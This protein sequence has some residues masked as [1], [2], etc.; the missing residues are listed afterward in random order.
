MDANEP[1]HDQPITS[2]GINIGKDVWIGA[3]TGIVDGV[4][5]GDGAVIG[6]GS[7]VTK[8]IPPYTK[9]AGNPAKAIGKREAKAPKSS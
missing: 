2:R 8:V 5:I 1:V 6:M 9:V 4:T 3:N 7:Q